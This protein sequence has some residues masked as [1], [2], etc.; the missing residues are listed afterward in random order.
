MAIASER[1][2]LS[3][4]ATKTAVKCSAALPKNGRRMTPI[5]RVGKPHPSAAASTLWTRTSAIHPTKTVARMRRIQAS[6]VV[7]FGSS[8]S[9]ASDVTSN[10]CECV[11]NWKNRD[12]PYIRRRTREA[13]RERLRMLESAPVCDAAA[14]MINARTASS[15][16]L[17][18]IERAS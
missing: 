17:P 10:K 6:F 9:S 5:N 14:G 7:I 4:P 1:S 15:S 8:I 18:F 3:F 13:Y 2:I 11:L 16:K 12:K